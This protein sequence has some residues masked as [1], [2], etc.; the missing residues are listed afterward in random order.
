MDNAQICDNYSNIP[1]SQTYRPAYNDL[2][3][4]KWHLLVAVITPLSHYEFS[5]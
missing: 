2:T 3:Q 4:W 1:L 5:V